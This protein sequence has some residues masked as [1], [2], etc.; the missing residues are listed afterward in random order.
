MRLTS[1]FRR[2]PRQII[3]LYAFCWNEERIIP[4]FLR[5]YEP[6]VDRLF[7][8]DDNSTDRSPELLRASRKVELRS[9]PR[10]GVSY[11][12]R[13]HAM[14]EY[15]WK[16]SRG[17]ADW[18][19]L[20][21]M[22][23]FLYHPDFHGYL[24]RSHEKGLTI[25]RANGFDM[26]APGFPPPAASL[27][28]TVRRGSRHFHYDKTSVF[29][30]DAIEQINFTPGRHLAEPSGRVV[31][32]HRREIKLLHYKNLGA[33]YLIQRSQELALRSSAADISAGYSLHNFR[34]AEELRRDFAERLAAATDVLAA[35]S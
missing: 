13:H 17:K 23:E 27:P 26:V 29:N 28:Q 15:V 4:F 20:C 7:I 3:H 35:E 33:D 5:H 30:P 25:I 32:N 19:V 2:A 18:V 22:D 24:A 14:F 8:Y 10:D 21:D 11:N 1:L 34:S 6:I 12:V 9:L 31:F 16:E